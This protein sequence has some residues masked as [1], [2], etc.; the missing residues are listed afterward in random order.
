MDQCAERKSNPDENST[1]SP[2]YT[3]SHLIL[4]LTKGF[5]MLCSKKLEWF[6]VECPSLK[7][8]NWTAAYSTMSIENHAKQVESRASHAWSLHKEVHPFHRP[9]EIDPLTTHNII[10][11]P[12]RTPKSRGLIPLK[13]PVSKLGNFG[14]PTH[15]VTSHPDTRGGA[16]ADVLL[17]NYINMPIPR[18]LDLPVLLD[19]RK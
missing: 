16:S 10:I 15:T 12:P 7:L 1:F 3:I 9:S 5:R 14:N 4:T 11:V 18:A 19:G 8:T 17:G 2:V 13:R 6:S